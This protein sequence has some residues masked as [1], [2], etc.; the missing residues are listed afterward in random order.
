MSAT[1]HFSWSASV[2]RP[3]TLQT[4]LGMPG[5]GPHLLC[6]VGQVLPC[7]RWLAGVVQDERQLG[8]PLGETDRLRE[9]V[10]ADQHV[11]S[12]SSFSDRSQS[13]LDIRSLE[14][15]RVGLALHEVAYGPQV[16]A[17]GPCPHVVEHVAD[18]GGRQVR[19]AD[20]GADQRVA[21][22]Q[23]EEVACLGQGGD[24]LDDHRARQPPSGDR[25]GR[26]RAQ[27]VRAEVAAEGL[28]TGFVQ[29]GL[30][31]ETQVP[32]VVVGVDE[33]L[34]VRH[35]RSRRGRRGRRTPSGTP[36]ASPRSARAASAPGS[37]RRRRVPGRRSARAGGRRTR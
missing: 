25:P 23:G 37:G 14:P 28:M 31:P 9:L 26:R 5:Q 2:T 15:V 1:V 32:H 27:G 30:R 8:E 19:P 33:G 10:A 36:G 22:G 4:G 6:P 29:P 3:E 34:D 35:E 7:E 24:A 13:A 16:P 21:V 18:G 12:E 11:V 20:D 17:S